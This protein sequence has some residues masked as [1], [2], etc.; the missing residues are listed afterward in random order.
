MALVYT[1]LFQFTYVSSPLHLTQDTCFDAPI[2][3]ASKSLRPSNLL[4]IAVTPP[5]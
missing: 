4:R 3:A 1:L 5:H 2:S